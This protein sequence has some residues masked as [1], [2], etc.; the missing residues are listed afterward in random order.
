MKTVAVDI[1][2]YDPHLED[3]GDGAIRN[4]G[5]ILCVGI[6]DGF[7]PAC[8]DV[9]HPY[10]REVLGDPSITKVFHNGVY[11]L[12]WLQLGYNIPV[13]GRCE[14]T[15]TREA[16]LDAYAGAY[17]LD[18]CCFRRGVIGKKRDTLED[19]WERQ[20]L[21]GKVM[22]NLH[23]VPRDIL[24]AYCNQDC[25]ATYELYFAQQP[26]LEKEDL[27]HVND[28]EVRLYPLLMEMKRNGFRIDWPACEALSNELNA[29]YN[30]GHQALLKQY[31]YLESYG[32]PIAMERLF[33]ELGIELVYKEGKKRP[34]FAQDVLERIHHPVIEQIKGL[35]QTNT[36]LNKFIDGAIPNYMYRGRIHSTII[37]MLR[38][39]GGTVT[40][41]MSSRDC[42]MQNI[43]ARDQKTG[44]EVRSLFLPEEGCSLGAWDYQ[45]IE[46][47]VFA[48]YATGEGSAQLRENM[49]NGMD[50]H[51][52]TMKLLG[53]SDRHLAK[54]LNF[55]CIS[56]ESFVATQ[57]GYVR[58]KSLLSTDRLTMGTGGWRAFIGQKPMYR[59]TLSNGHQ[60]DV[61]TDHPFQ[62]AGAKDIN[63]GDVFPVRPCTVWGKDYH[64]FLTTQYIAPNHGWNGSVV[65][66]EG[67]AYLLG[68]YLGNGTAHRGGT[69]NN[70]AALSF[71]THSENTQLLQDIFQ[72]LHIVKGASHN[73][74]CTW[75]VT[76]RA[77]TEWVTSHCGYTKTKHVPDFI[78]SSPR[79][80]VIAFMIGFLD[81]DGTVYNSRPQFVNTNENL[82]RGL[83][84]LATMLGWNA[85]WGSETYN[86]TV[87][88]GKRHTGI[89]YRLR[90]HKSQLLHD[91][92]QGIRRHGDWMPRTRW[93]VFPGRKQKVWVVSK[94]ELGLQPTW[95]MSVDPPHWYEAECCI[96][97]NSIY[98]L[99]SRSFA[100]RFFVDLLPAA[101][102]LGMTV[103]QYAQYRMD[104]YH[105]KLPYV[106]PSCQRIQNTGKSRGYV[107]TIHGR[108]QRVPTDGKL[109]KL[110]NYLVQGS[111]AD[112]LKAGLVAGWE[113]GV[114]DVLKIHM[115]VHDENVFS[116][117][118]TKEGVQAAQ[119]FARIMAETTQLKVPITVDTEAGPNWGHC[120]LE[121]WNQLLD[122]YGGKDG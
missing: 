24:E 41:R 43:P 54:Q 56:P 7:I 44:K 52:F 92:L 11:D 3:F 48:N 85:A 17:N 90:F 33:R 99:G 55:T 120:T 29:R 70:W 78:Y 37:P 62:H 100:E 18:A 74:W 51:S 49:A 46:Y 87:P 10:V 20:G 45:Q 76:C 91:E 53:W 64:M 23:V 101:E 59:F 68:I 8:Y 104:E 75:S 115:T 113:A 122:R 72:P 69:Q 102:K 116:I 32:S 83:A 57:R 34:S 16:L 40:G 108:R 22:K 26:L 117:P 109:Y 39:E 1:E 112:I 94:E 42:N 19:W 73:D 38:D 47:R 15:M 121:N 66:D 80:V 82:M 63:V 5:R 71:I 2:T 60:F 27:V 93:G 89:L 98:G 88:G 61:T 13:K 35:K 107:R 30:A 12:S 6:Y 77:M 21:K 79:S 65:V 50:Y 96:N 36:V 67:I 106:R 97:H 103:P 31:P 58:A 95:C 118:H 81:S 111:A 28:L 84:R 110:V 4:D 114:F 86:T 14:D 119:E 105:Q 25:I 9:E